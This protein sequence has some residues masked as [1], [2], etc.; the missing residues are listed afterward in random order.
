MKKDVLVVPA[1]YAIL[2]AK[3]ANRVHFRHDPFEMDYSFNGI[4]TI[5][6]PKPPFSLPQ[7][8]ATDVVCL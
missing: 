3:H 7:K 5:P 8:G 1:E 2:L 6:G 4:L